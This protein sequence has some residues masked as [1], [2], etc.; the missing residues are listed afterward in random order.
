MEA[1]G[2]RFFHQVAYLSILSRAQFLK[3]SVSVVSR[4]EFFDRP[5]LVLS[6]ARLDP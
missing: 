3:G 1:L 6:M 2:T 4:I 5:K